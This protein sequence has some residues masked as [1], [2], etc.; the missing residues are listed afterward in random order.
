MAVATSPISFVI[1]C[2]GE[3]D[4]LRKYGR[5]A[6]TRDAVQMIRSTIRTRERSSRG[7]GRRVVLHLG[8]FFGERHA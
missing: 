5:G 4:G 3:A 8:D 7:N 1:E 6:G 2:R